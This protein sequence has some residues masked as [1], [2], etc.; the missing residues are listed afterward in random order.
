MGGMILSETRKVRLYALIS[1]HLQTLFALLCTL[2]KRILNEI[3]HKLH[4][5]L[6]DPRFSQIT[7]PINIMEPWQS[8]G[9]LLGFGTAYYIFTNKDK[10]LKRTGTPATDSQDIVASKS[11]RQRGEGKSKRKEQVFTV[12]AALEPVKDVV[13]EASASITKSKFKPKEK[14]KKGRKTQEST[15]T[16]PKPFEVPTH[17]STDDT[18]DETD[19]N[20]WAER[21]AGLKTGTSLKAP[22]RKDGRSKTVK[23]NAANATPLTSK[24]NGDTGN[25][26]IVDYMPSGKDVSDMLPASVPGPSSLRITEPINP[27]P[28]K[29]Q[30]QPK[31][32][33]PAQESKKQRQNRRKAEEKRLQKE[34]DEKDRRILLEKQ[35]RTARENRGEPAKNGVQTAKAQSS[36]WTRST[37]SNITASSSDAPMLDT[38]ENDA[39]STASSSNA[40]NSNASTNTTGK[41]LGEFLSEDE[42]VRM[43]MEDSGWNTV[44]NRRPRKKTTGSDTTAEDN[45][46]DTGNAEEKT[47][48]KETVVPMQTFTRNAEPIGGPSI[49]D[50]VSNADESDWAVV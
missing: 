35:L 40:P 50:V 12:T 27:A 17:T 48:K 22:E 47:D 39:A 38:F 11:S 26:S 20:D 3:L 42:Q 9:L 36:A 31:Q 15:K 28:S 2:N 32:A 45:V 8:W 23:Q 1:R 30:Q 4:K 6:S 16:D 29:K 43:A 25:T 13:S 24:S 49:Y 44:P 33:P 41:N 10:I 34:Q 37:A 46:S 7:R 21:L 14:E 5:P 18:K 19:D